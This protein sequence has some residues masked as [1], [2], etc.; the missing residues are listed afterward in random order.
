[1]GIRTSSI[2]SV[3]ADEATLFDF[4]CDAPI[5]RRPVNTVATKPRPARATRPRP[6]HDEH[7]DAGQRFDVFFTH[8]QM[9]ALN[10][11]SS[12]AFERWGIRVNKSQL[13]RALVGAL[14]N[15]RNTLR[16]LAVQM[17]ASPLPS[18]PPKAAEAEVH[19]RFESQLTALLTQ[20]IRSNRA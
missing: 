10:A 17:P 4:V 13:L 6:T 3:G 20:A 15:S 8:E 19:R 12:L 2:R 7:P 11:A 5:T 16:D 9:V 1:M 18:A 14:E